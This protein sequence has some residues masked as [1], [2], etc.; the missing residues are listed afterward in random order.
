MR[1]IDSK[2]DSYAIYEGRC[3]IT[4]PT[5]RIVVKNNM[6][7]T[8]YQHHRL[9]SFRNINHAKHWIDK[10]NRNASAR[11]NAVKKDC[12]ARIATLTNE[13]LVEDTEASDT[14]KFYRERIT[15]L[16]GT[17]SLWIKRDELKND[18]VVTLYE[19]CIK[20]ESEVNRL[21]QG[22]QNMIDDADI[23]RI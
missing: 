8:T 11:T 2:I 1:K 7:D 10:L 4:E 23:D 6:N 9:T 5:G 16:Q 3:I 22:M 15:E 19:K 21:K 17:L 12:D 14:I 20:L 13:V 18:E